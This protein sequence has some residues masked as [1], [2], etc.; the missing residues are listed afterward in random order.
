MISNW[1]QYVWMRPGKMLVVSIWSL[2]FTIRL[3]NSTTLTFT[4]SS[5]L[6]LLTCT[7]M[8]TC[9]STKFKILHFLSADFVYLKP[10]IKTCSDN[11][12]LAV[13]ISPFWRVKRVWEACTY[14]LSVTTEHTVCVQCVLGQWWTE[15]GWPLWCTLHCWSATFL[16]R[17]PL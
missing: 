10:I 11:F 6:F 7:A 4:T 12:S 15:I 2:A 5:F 17:G 16:V 14:T 9:P 13:L 8:L 3:N 1:T